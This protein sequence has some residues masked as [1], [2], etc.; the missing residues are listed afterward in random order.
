M[1]FV[2]LEFLCPEHDRFESLEDRATAPDAAPCPQCGASSPWVI[3]APMGRVKLGSVTTGKFEPPPHRYALDTRPLA[4][5]MKYSDWKKKRDALVK[6]R[7]LARV[8]GETG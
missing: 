8:R 4:D 7:T 2:L 1:S 5:G 6:E 3:S